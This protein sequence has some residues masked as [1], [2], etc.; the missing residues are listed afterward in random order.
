MSSDSN[1]ILTIGTYIA[2]SHR[3]SLKIII[4][5]IK[6]HNLELYINL[7]KLPKQ[8]MEITDVYQCSRCNGFDLTPKSKITEY[9]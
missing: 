7:L 9:R 3:P 6:G 4:C 2:K 5:G 1:D 8:Q